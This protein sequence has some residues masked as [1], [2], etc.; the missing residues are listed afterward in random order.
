MIQFSLVR[1]AGGTSNSQRTIAASICS[2]LH[3][4]PQDQIKAMVERR[5]PSFQCLRVQQHVSRLYVKLR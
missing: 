2:S 3:K 1:A 4:Q 5:T